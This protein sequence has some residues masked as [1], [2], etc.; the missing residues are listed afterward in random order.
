MLSHFCL[1]RFF[2][3][4]LIL[5]IN[6]KA[7][8][9]S[10]WWIN[11]YY[12]IRNLSECTIVCLEKKLLVDIVFIDWGMEAVSIWSW[13]LVQ[14]AALWSSSKHWGLRRKDSRGIV[15]TRFIRS[16]SP[17]SNTFQVRGYI[18]DFDNNNMHNTGGWSKAI[19]INTI[20][21]NEFFKT[22]PGYEVQNTINS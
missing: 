21:A 6:V 4:L 8:M 19:N 2:S 15:P 11:Y 10:F 13:Y 3:H 14:K 22:S 12:T 5:C 9:H 16:C 7:R 18:Y 1:L 17:S 20:S